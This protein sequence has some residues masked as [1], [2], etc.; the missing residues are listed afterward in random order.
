MP[1][2][3]GLEVL[4][5]LVAWRDVAPVVMINGQGDETVALE[6]MKLGTGD[7]IVKDI[8]GNYLTLLPA[9]IE[10][11]IDQQRLAKEKVQA[12]AAL[13]QTLDELE[14]RVQARTIELQQTNQKLLAEIEERRH[15]EEVAATAASAHPEHRGHRDRW[16]YHD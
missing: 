2:R 16:Y 5:T 14:S 4:H 9:V 7:Y 3:D 15:V 8:A 1:V 10:R 6:A 12:E 11:L 13:H